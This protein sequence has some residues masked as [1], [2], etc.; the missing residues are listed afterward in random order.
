MGF[1]LKN[2][3]VVCLVKLKLNTCLPAERTKKGC[4]CSLSA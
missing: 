4:L 3:L 2:A 1:N